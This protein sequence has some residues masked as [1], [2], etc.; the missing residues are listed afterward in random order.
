MFILDLDNTLW[1]GILGE[2]GIE[3]IQIGVTIQKHNVQQQ[4]RLGKQGIIHVCSK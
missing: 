3:G 1:G 2:D 4:M